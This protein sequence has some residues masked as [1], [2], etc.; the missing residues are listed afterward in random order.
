MTL[1]ILYA[2]KSVKML[3]IYTIYV[4]GFEF[5]IYDKQRNVCNVLHI[6]FLGSFHLTWRFSMSCF[7]FICFFVF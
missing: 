2:G 3:V 4:I 7:V 6:S 1:C 5:E